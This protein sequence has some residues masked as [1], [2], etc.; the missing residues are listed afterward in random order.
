MRVGKAAVR[1]VNG[2]TAHRAAAA[3][4]GTVFPAAGAGPL[5]AGTAAAGP[6]PGRRPVTTRI[7][8][9]FDRPLGFPALHRH[10][11]LVLAAG[12]VTDPP[13]FP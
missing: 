12:R 10:S 1:A 4:G 8:A 9:A 3:E 7:S 13:P 6:P 5:P 11:R 2:P